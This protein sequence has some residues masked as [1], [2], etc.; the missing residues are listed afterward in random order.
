MKRITLNE[1]KES[2]TMKVADIFAVLFFIFLAALVFFFPFGPCGWCG[3]D[4]AGSCS[5]D[6]TGLKNFGKLVNKFPY[7][8]G[9]LKVAILAT[10]GEMIKTRGRTGSYKTDDLFL[11][12]VVWGLY[13]MLFTL[14]FALF[15]QGIAALSGTAVW[16]FKVD[17][18]WN[19]LIFAF[20]TSFWLNIIFCYPMMLSHEW[21]NTCIKNKRFI[22]GTEFIKGLDAHAWGSF[23]PKS[24]IVFWV[25]AHTITFCLP[26]DYRI[27][28]SAFLSLALGF[29][30]TIKPKH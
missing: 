11:K 19:T 27:L 17:N 20:S 21:F 14:V 22:G 12:F 9:F 7:I 8:S 28:M 26:P 13:G 16:P 6:L 18:C 15:A 29:I 24:I 4:I 5:G 25:P 3:I 30:L 2:A 10:F 23:L 1:R